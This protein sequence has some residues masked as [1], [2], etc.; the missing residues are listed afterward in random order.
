M[1]TKQV[2]PPLTRDEWLVM[3]GKQ[4]EAMICMFMGWQ[5][6]PSSKPVD[7]WADKVRQISVE[8]KNHTS[9]TG[10]GDIRR[11]AGA[12]S[13]SKKAIFVA[14]HYS[15]GYF[16]YVAEL[17]RKEWKKIELIPAHTIIG[18]LVLTQ[19]E[20]EEYQPYTKNG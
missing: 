8:I 4:F 17:E 12:M 15:K 10:V 18:E 6:N 2:N 14:W 1:G 3:E 11:L 20:R 19:A 16:E 9:Q 7:G 13:G 5:H